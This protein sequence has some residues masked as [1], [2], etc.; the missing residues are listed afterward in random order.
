MISETLNRSCEEMKKRKSNTPVYYPIMLNIE[1]KRCVVVGGGNIALRKIRMLLDCGAD[2]TV[3]SP[4]PHLG[5]AKLSE[6]KAIHLIHR[7][8]KFGDLMDA[9]IA[10]ASTDVREINRMVAHEANQLGIPVNV[11]DDPRLSSFIVPS[12]FRRENLTIAVSSAGTSP[13]LARKIRTHLE[14]SLG[15]EYATL[16]SLIGEVRSALRERGCAA[17]GEAWQEVLDLDA[18]IRLMQ[19]GQRKKAETVL[20]TKL[21][22]FRGG[23]E[24][25]E[26]FEKKETF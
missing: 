10:V 9:T 15:K 23:I 24:S 13:A 11:V 7:N 12:F 22:A 19:K 16:L 4:K 5:V 21:K 2:V 26:D 20:L 3:V 17:D 18:L 1:G 14:K 8:Y 25:Q 6:K